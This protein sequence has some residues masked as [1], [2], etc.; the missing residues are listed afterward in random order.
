[1]ADHLVRGLGSAFEVDR[2]WIYV[3]ASERVPQLFAQWQRDP[4]WP[5]APPL[6]YQVAE[7]ERLA[8]RLWDNG[9][10]IGI[11]DHRTYEPPRPA[12]R[13]SG[14]PRRSGPARRWS[15]RSA[16]TPARSASSGS[17]GRPCPALD[18]DRDRR[19]AVPGRRPGPQPHPGARDRRRRPRRSGA[20]RARPGQVGLRL[21]RL[22]RA[23]HPADLDQRLPGDA[24][25]RRRR[26]AAR[27]GPGRCSPSSTA[28]PPGCAT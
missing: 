11:D 18:A 9:H 5:L 1:M 6:D 16:T 7:I 21:H 8:T 17:H 24:A 13:C 3:F 28:T 19:G 27:A 25:G 14:W 12:A 26:R 15:S 23:A 2:A 20:A 22:A 10:T 4:L